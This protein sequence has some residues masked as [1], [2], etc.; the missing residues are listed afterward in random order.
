VLAEA[1]RLGRRML[2]VER[3]PD[4]D[5]VRDRA[6]SPGAVAPDLAD[7]ALAAAARTGGADVFAALVDELARST[8]AQLRRRILA[9][10]AQ[11]RQ[12]PLIARALDLALDPRLRHNER[13]IALDGL[14]GAPDTRDAAWAWLTAHFDALMPLLPDRYGGQLPRAI[15]MCGRRPIAEVRAFFAPRVEQLTGGPR[16]LAQALES[17]EQC[18]ARVAAQRASVVAYLDARG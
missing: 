17:A 12:A 5:P 16:N 15:R 1:A 3:R 4:A 18:V 9:A 13:L 2:G 8:D 14:L 7:V 6:R 11:T 10:L